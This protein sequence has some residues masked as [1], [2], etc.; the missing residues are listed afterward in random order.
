MRSRARPYDGKILLPQELM[1]WH[2]ANGKGEMI[3]K[4]KNN[5]ELVHSNWVSV[6]KAPRDAYQDD[7]SE[8]EDAAEV[9]KSLRLQ[10][11]QL[12]QGAGQENIL[13]DMGLRPLESEHLKINGIRD[14]HI[15]TFTNMS[16]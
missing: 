13:A 11:K 9:A 1:T 12:Y 6:G 4:V 7:Y 2:P 14:G 15:V 5:V 16:K 8:E 10:M 3:Q